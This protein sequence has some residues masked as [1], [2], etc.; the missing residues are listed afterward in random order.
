M[1]RAIVKMRHPSIA[2]MPSTIAMLG[3]VTCE[4]LTHG[5]TGLGWGIFGAAILFPSHS[6]D[7]IVG[8]TKKNKKQA[9]LEEPKNCKTGV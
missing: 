6:W 3:G 5:H 1:K 9:L 7:I 4:V 8:E 2:Y